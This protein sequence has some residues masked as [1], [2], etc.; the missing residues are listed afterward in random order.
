MYRCMIVNLLYLTNSR[1]SII[2][3]VGLVGR[4]QENLKGTH[5]I[6]VK[7]IFRHLQ[8]TI[9]YGLWYP[10]EK[11]LALRTCIDTDWE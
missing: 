2:Q 5:V 9:D 6:A 4:F 7:R 11:K 3:A 8:G 10:K 1:C